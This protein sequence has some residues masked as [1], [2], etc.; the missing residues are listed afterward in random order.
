MRYLSVKNFEH[1]QHYK[2]RRPPWIKLYQE[3]LEDYDFTRLQDASRSHLLAIWL[4]ASRYENRIPYDAAWIGRAIMAS[5]P[6]D[7]DVLIKAGFLTVC[8]GASSALA[9]R[10]QDAKP[11]TE[12]EGEK[13]TE[14]KPSSSARERES[15]SVEEAEAE[16]ALAQRLSDEGERAALTA[17]LHVVPNRIAWIAVMNG[18]LDGL[19]GP[20]LTTKQLAAAMRDWMGNG[21][22]AK[23]NLR[24]FRGYLN[25]AAKPLPEHEGNGASNPLDALQRWAKQHA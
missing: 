18:A 13:E 20:Q 1:F 12:T 25:R 19:D 10:K 16:H 14:K 9:D 8:D 4:L 21:A 22:S 15:V 11:E 7:L 5:S 2:D 23:P 17:L 6:V 24:H 3:V